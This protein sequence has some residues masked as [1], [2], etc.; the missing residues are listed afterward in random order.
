MEVLV[1]YHLLRI[2]NL[3]LNLALEYCVCTHTAVFIYS[4]TKFNAL[5]GV[6]H[7]VSLSQVIIPKHWKH[8]Y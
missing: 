1:Y 2:L 4:S 8:A 6:K 7:V 5:L 3:V